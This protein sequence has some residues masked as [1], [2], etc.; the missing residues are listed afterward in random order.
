MIKIGVLGAGHLGKIHIRL[1]LELKDVYE[2]VGFYDPSP[3][4]REEVSRLNLIVNHLM[5]LIS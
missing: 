1:I 5:I 2:F 4:V 3:A